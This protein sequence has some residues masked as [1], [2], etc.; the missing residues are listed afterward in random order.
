MPGLS[1]PTNPNLVA[2]LFEFPGPQI[3]RLAQYLAE[4]PGCQIAGSTV[5]HFVLIIAESFPDDFEAAIQFSEIIRS[6]GHLS[7]AEGLLEAIVSVAQHFELLHQQAIATRT[8]IRCRACGVLEPVH[9][10]YDRI[11][12]VT[13]R[14][15]CSLR[16]HPRNLSSQQGREHQ[17]ERGTEPHHID[18]PESFGSG[19][20]IKIWVCFLTESVARS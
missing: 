18:Q 5:R 20:H 10:G 13:L 16:F 9:L 17:P 15:W 7:G 11:L 6:I 2:V 1:G 3:C 19:F 14:H 12:S 4:G 8:V